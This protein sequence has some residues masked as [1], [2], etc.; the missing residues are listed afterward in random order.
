MITYFDKIITILVN[1]CK[2][3]DIMKF[4]L[5]VIRRQEERGLTNLTT[6]LSRVVLG[7]VPISHHVGP[8][9]DPICPTR[10]S[11]VPIEVLSVFSLEL[12]CGRPS[13]WIALQESMR[14]NEFH[15]FGVIVELVSFE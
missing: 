2:N 8:I 4:F 15:F 6:R 11:F 13:F 10:H 3:L 7:I 12:K 5:R 14:S 9:E 1:A